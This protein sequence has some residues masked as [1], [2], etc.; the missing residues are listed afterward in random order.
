MGEPS[1]FNYNTDDFVEIEDEMF[2]DENEEKNM[3]RKGK[4]G[5]LPC[6]D[7]WSNERLAQ[8]NK[9]QEKLFGI[10]KPKRKYCLNVE[11]QNKIMEYYIDKNS[12][13]KKAVE[14]YMKPEPKLRD[15][16]AEVF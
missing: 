5:G 15:Q 6:Q 2:E 1:S 11:I 8:I 9:C 12:N 13:F 4:G 16:M 10:E 14:N 3:S 7:I